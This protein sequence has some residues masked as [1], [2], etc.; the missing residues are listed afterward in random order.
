[1]TLSNR[2]LAVYEEFTKVVVLS[3][4]HRLK[5]QKLDRTQ[6]DPGIEAFDERCVRFREIMMRLRD[7]AITHEDYY[8]LCRLK[9]SRR[10]LTDRMFFRDAPVLMEFRRTTA[11][12]EDKNCEVFNHARVRAHAR[13]NKC[14]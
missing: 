10:S 14:P 6:A 5:L 7:M 12:S 4:A 3:T 11:T 1:M 2:G 13:S 8:W 9:R